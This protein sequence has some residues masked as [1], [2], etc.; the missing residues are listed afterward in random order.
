LSLH[1]IP[2]SLLGLILGGLA[3]LH[4]YW[5]AGGRW[6]AEAAVPELSSGKPRFRPGPGACLA[7]AVMLSIGALCAILPFDAWWRI[8]ALRAMAVVFGLRAIG[9]FRYV[10]FF[11][12]VTRSRFAT[13]DTRFYSPLCVLLAVLAALS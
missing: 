4:V 6:G 8:L 3:I 10:G 9:D 11:K 5:A 2:S 12:R 7:V 1:T 13:L